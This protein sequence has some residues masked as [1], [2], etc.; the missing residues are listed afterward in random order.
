MGKKKK[1]IAKLTEEQYFAYIAGLKNDAALF[2]SNGD[3]L[4]PSEYASDKSDEEKK[5]SD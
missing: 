1:R 5:N 2:D 3:I 4:I